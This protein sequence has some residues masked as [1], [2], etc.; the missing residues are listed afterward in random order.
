MKKKKVHNKDGKILQDVK[1]FDY[2]RALD[3]A[4]DFLQYLIRQQEVLAKVALKLASSSFSFEE[5]MNYTMQKIGEHTDVSRV[6]IFEDFKHKTHTKNTY[7]WVAKGVEPQIKK[8]KDIKYK[9]IPS[10]LKLLKT[11][12]D[13]VV[14][15]V[16]KLPTDLQEI[17]IP[18]NIKAIIIFPLKIQ[19][20]KFGFI[21]FDEDRRSRNWNKIE[22]DLIRIMSFLIASAFEQK[23]NHDKLKTQVERSEK[24]NKFLV[25]RELRI[26]DLKKKLKRLTNK[27]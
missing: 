26:T 12:G 17:F 22:V 20:K 7:E 14:D 19:G 4:S 25:N 18:Q 9:D 1:S 21:G 6:Y 13:F 15:D 8:L 24:M 16:K 27:K 2:S 10:F 23:H 5:K 11:D 3:G